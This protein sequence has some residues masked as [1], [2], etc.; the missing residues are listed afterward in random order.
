M[1]LNSKDYKS[2]EKCL[3]YFYISVIIIKLLYIFS[4]VIIL[5]GCTNMLDIP[6]VFSFI[7]SSVSV[8]NML[9]KSIIFIYFMY[10]LKKTNIFEF[11]RN[12]KPLT[13]YFILDLLSFMVNTY[14]THI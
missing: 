2:K 10:L 9:W 4:I 3:L 14:I 7:M 1:I 13:I 12:V 8:C 6:R 5:L 11:N